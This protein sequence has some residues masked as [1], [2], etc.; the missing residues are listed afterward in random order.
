MQKLPCS[1]QAMREMD[2]VDWH[3]YYTLCRCTDSSG[4]QWCA[5]EVAQ[6]KS[7]FT[8]EKAIAPMRH[9]KTTWVV[10]KLI[11]YN[12]FKR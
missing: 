1:M 5:T 4:E 7:L 2:T 12:G 8:P 11:Y 9:P 3:I 10:F 6:D